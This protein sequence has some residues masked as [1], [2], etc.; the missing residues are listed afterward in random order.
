LLFPLTYW[1]EEDFAGIAWDCGGVTTGSVTVPLVLAM[2]MGIGGELNV[3]DGF[4]VLAMAS[5]YPVITVL[6]YGMIVRFR[7]RR[8]FQLPEK[9]TENG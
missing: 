9:V 2:G 1:S 6:L 7:Q 5:V 8:S 4:G 3:I